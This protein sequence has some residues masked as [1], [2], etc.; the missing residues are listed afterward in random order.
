[1][2]RRPLDHNPRLFHTPGLPRSADRASVERARVGN[3][4]SKGLCNHGER[5][6]SGVGGGGG[7]WRFFRWM[8][9]KSSPPQNSRTEHWGG[10]PGLGGTRWGN[11]RGGSETARVGRIT[12]LPGRRD[13]ARAGRERHPFRLGQS[14]NHPPR[15]GHGSHGAPKCDIIRPEPQFRRRA[16]MGDL[17]KWLYD[18]SVALFKAFGTAVAEYPVPTV[19]VFAAVFYFL[20]GF[21]FP[22]HRNLRVS[23]GVEN[24]LR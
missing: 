3:R 13:H 7:G 19:V 17:F 12:A 23:E 9:P 18:L 5:S 11:G 24:L 21:N 2:A 20:R 22:A 8:G 14:P 4:R 6:W 1:M 15:E 10:S 16:A